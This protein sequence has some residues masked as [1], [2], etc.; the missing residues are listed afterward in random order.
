MMWMDTFPFPI[1]GRQWRQYYSLTRR[2]STRLSQWRPAVAKVF[3]GLFPSES[4]WSLMSPNIHVFV[5][6][7]AIVSLY[8]LRCQ[9]VWCLD[10]QECQRASRSGNL[11]DL[12]VMPRTCLATL[13][14]QRKRWGGRKVVDS[15]S[16]ALEVIASSASL[17]IPAFLRANAD[18]FL[19]RPST[20]AT[21]VVVLSSITGVSQMG[22]CAYLPLRPCSLLRDREETKTP[23]YLI[24]HDS[25]FAIGMAAA[26]VSYHHSSGEWTIHAIWKSVGRGGTNIVIGLVGERRRC[27]KRGAEVERRTIH[28]TVTIDIGT[29]AT[30]GTRTHV[31]FDTGTLVTFDTRTHVTFDTGTLVTLDTGTHVTFDIRTHVTIDIGTH[32]TL[33]TRTHVTFDTGTLVTFDTRTHVTFDTETLVTF[34]TRTHVTFDTGTLVTFG[35]RTHATFDTRTH[36]TFDTGTLVTF[37]TRTHVTFGT[38]TLVT[39]DTGTHT[40]EHTLPSTLEH[41]LPSTLERTLLSALE[42]TLPSTLE[43]TLPSTLEHTLPS[44]LERTLLSTLEHTLPSTLEHKLPSTLEHTIY[45]RRRKI[46][47]DVTGLERAEFSSLPSRSTRVALPCHRRAR[48]VVARRLAEVEGTKKREKKMDFRRKEAFLKGKGGGGRKKSHTVL[49]HLNEKRRRQERNGVEE[50]EVQMGSKSCKGERPLY[51]F[52]SFGRETGAKTRRS[53][54]EKDERQEI[55]HGFPLLWRISLCWEDSVG[56]EGGILSLVR[57]LLTDGSFRMKRKLGGGFGGN[58][59]EWAFGQMRMS[60]LVWFTDYKDKLLEASVSNGYIRRMV[61]LKDTRSPV[62]DV[63]GLQLL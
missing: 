39:L 34:D 40:L 25:P 15:Q 11:A 46:E 23:Q 28:E 18:S 27:G 50:N 53:E 48:R 57:T 13:E 54:R 36:A 3:V 56:G 51:G 19:R 17:G 7:S 63:L 21:I 33:G 26:A 59:R 58:L 52:R 61:Q 22:S 30:L 37:D 47:A 42:H 8:W 35:T 49:Y 55:E 29:H 43:H 24:M 5:G 31:T 6:L 41:T 4:V 10:S 1:W 16:D 14:V 44:T 38:G 45:Q 32:A 20:L 60:R 62:L 9:H 2:K 12:P